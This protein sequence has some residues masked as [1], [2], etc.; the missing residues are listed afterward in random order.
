MDA[1]KAAEHFVT[2]LHKAC[3]GLLQSGQDATVPI[4]LDGENAW[5]LYVENGRPFLQALYRRISEDATIDAMTVT[6]ALEGAAPARL[7]HIYPGSWIDGNFDIWI[8][9]EEDNRAWELLL[10]ARRS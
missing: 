3:A 2:D 9:A 10:R 1:E 6:E 5:E 8:G 4:I 7:E